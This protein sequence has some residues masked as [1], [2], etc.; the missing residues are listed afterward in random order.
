MPC[1]GA[2][3][4]VDAATGDV[5]ADR[6]RDEVAD[7]LCEELRVAG[8]PGRSSAATHSSPRRLCARRSGRDRCEV[9]RLA[10]LY[11]VPA[12]DQGEARF[13]QPLLLPA[14]VKDVLADL[15]PHGGVGGRVGECATKR[16]WPAYVAADASA[17]GILDCLSDLGGC[18]GAV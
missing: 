16:S 5:V 9:D 2:V 14:G 4:E 12:P 3:C 1:V 17:P 6:V 11:P 15:T 8:R 18:E 10:S 13:E 7:E